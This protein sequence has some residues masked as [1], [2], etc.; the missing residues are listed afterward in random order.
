MQQWQS[1][2]YLDV[3]LGPIE[4]VKETTFMTTSGGCQELQLPADSA[5]KATSAVNVDLDTD[6]DIEGADLLRDLESAL[7]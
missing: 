6:D 2:D 5:V 7:D 4:D 3:E 1:K